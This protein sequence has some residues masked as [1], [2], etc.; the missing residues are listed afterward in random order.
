MTTNELVR[1]LKKHGCRLIAHSK[2]HDVY[3]SPITGAELMVGRHAKEEVPKGTLH[4]IL[5]D[6]GIK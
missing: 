6:A 3:K 5:V 1:L 4:K 2:K